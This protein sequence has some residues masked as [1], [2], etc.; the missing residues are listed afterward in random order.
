MKSKQMAG[1]LLAAIMLAGIAQGALIARD[2]LNTSVSGDPSNGLYD[3][4]A[5]LNTQN[6]TGG[7]IVGFSG[8]WTSSA[9]YDSYA[10]MVRLIGRTHSSAATAYRALSAS[11]GGKTVAYARATMRVA[12]NALAGAFVLA[13][14]SDAT[15]SSMIGSAVG[16]VWDG[17]NWDMT[18][19]YRN[20]GGL[21]FTT[22]REDIAPNTYHDFYW[23]MDQGTGTIKVWVDTNDTS[24]VADLTVTDWA[25]TVSDI[26]HFTSSSHKTGSGNTGYLDN[27]Q[28]GDTGGDIGM[29]GSSG[30]LFALYGYDTDL[31]IASSALGDGS[32]T[33]AG[34]AAVYTD[35]N[36]WNKVQNTLNSAPVTVSLLDGSYDSAFSLDSMG[37]ADHTLI[38]SGA[39][40]DGVVFNGAVS[41][42]FALKGCQNM[43]LENLNFTGAGNG[44]AFK[45]TETAVGVVSSNVIV[46]NCDWYDMM[47]IIYG[48]SGVHS[49]SHHV[50]FDNCTFKRIGSGRLAHMMYHAYD[51]DYVSAVNCRF[52]DCAGSYVRFRAGSDYGVVSG[53]TF[54]STQTYVNKDPDDEKF[55]EIPVFNDVDPGDEYFG[56]DFTFTNNTFQFHS[57]TPPA[58]ITIQFYHSGYNPPG[59]NHLM[60]LADGAVLEG[61]DWSAKK[62]LLDTDCGIDFDR[63]ALGANS[64]S[65]ETERIVFRSYA[66]YGAP[67][68]GW[69][70]RADISD[71]VFH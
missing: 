2:E 40:A 56:Q 51:A 27:I 30:F 20:G 3:S 7:T 47:N 63:I 32:G 13:G 23:S 14:F 33:D 66:N 18:L 62:A 41:T 68:Q 46:R 31:H 16:Y 28:L 53:C 64:W 25:G 52:E 67:D 65:N 6:V 22:I 15:M 37:N 45:I 38:L 12:D 17:S 60:S 70:D 54:V 4:G 57:S 8:E 10:Q 48:A 36:F 29:T 1:L 5:D 58:R 11:M 24:A 61:S 26:T 34:N 35:A 43:V 21:T 59:M 71:I 19:R 39:S 9:Y 42:L 50:T 55:V 44:Y 69:N 49:G